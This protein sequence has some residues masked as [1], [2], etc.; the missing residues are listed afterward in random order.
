MGVCGESVSDRWRYAGFQV[1]YRKGKF[2][3]NRFEPVQG[4]SS[5]M[6]GNVIAVLSHSGGQTT[7]PLA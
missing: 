4:A 1:G 3:A 7:R 6:V 5:A 2:A